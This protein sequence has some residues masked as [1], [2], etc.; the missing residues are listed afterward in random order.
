MLIGDLIETSGDREAGAWNIAVLDDGNGIR[1]G[2]SPPYKR[3]PNLP[4]RPSAPL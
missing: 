2:E 4:G 3:C 1:V